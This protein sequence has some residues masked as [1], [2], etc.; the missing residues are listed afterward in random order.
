VELIVRF[1]AGGTIVALFALIG[2]VL[3]PQG[4]AGLFGA[5]PSGALARRRQLPLQLTSLSGPHLP[6]ISPALATRGPSRA[7]AGHVTTK[8]EPLGGV[9]SFGMQTS[10]FQ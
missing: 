4:F 9:P 3:K 5:A 10:K 6:P 8:A 2:D 1:L 7:G